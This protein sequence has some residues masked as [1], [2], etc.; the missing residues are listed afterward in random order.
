MRNILISDYFKLEVPD[1]TFWVGVMIFSS[2]ISYGLELRK[3]VEGL[4]GY[5]GCMNHQKDFDYFFKKLDKESL[6]KY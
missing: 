6:N 5:R 1:E 4:A 2:W 3:Q